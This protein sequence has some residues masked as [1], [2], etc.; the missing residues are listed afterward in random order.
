MVGAG[1]VVAAAAVVAPGGVMADE[2]RAEPVPGASHRAVDPFDLDGTGTAGAAAPVSR[3]DAVVDPFETRGGD[4][5][6]RSPGTTPEPTGF[7][8]LRFR[9]GVS[10][11]QLIEA[12]F[13]MDGQELPVLTGADAGKDSLIFEGKLR[14][15]RHVVSARI[16]YQGEKRGPFTY[17]TGYKMTVESEQVLTVPEGRSVGFTIAAQKNARVDAPVEKQVA[18]TVLDSAQPSASRR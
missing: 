6:V 4:G 18:I 3:S 13:V 17:L 1:F 12:R 10:K 15:G 9:N 14:P 5:T 2:G 11:F 16:V 7:A 8:T